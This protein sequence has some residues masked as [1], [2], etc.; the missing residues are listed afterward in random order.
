MI[1]NLQV[2]QSHDSSVG[3]CC[4][5]LVSPHL[6]FA[7]QIPDLLLLQLHVHAELLALGLQLS[8]ASS[9]RVGGL[10]PVGRE[11]RAE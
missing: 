7:L 10:H 11:T 2:V 5:A 9:Q 8:D 1:V 4:R 6:A 3:Y